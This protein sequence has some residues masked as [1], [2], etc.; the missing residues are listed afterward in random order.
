MYPVK[1]IAAGLLLFAGVTGAAIAQETCGLCQNEVVTNG[2]LAKCF[3]GEYEKL[4]QQ[5]GAAVAVDLNN[6]EVSR[7]VVEALP[8]P[9]SG[10]I[11]PDLE[12][13]VS[14]SQLEC[15]KRKLEEPGLVLDPTA[16]I[17]LDAC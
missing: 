4:A 12:F 5:S 16:T 3:L 8:T 17:A 11:E 10:V 6:C 1:S 15:L 9:N 13:M 7:G 14:R 2:E